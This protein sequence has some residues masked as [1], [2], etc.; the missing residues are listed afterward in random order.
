VIN[1]FTCIRDTGCYTSDS[2]TA[3][4]SPLSSRFGSI[5]LPEAPGLTLGVRVMPSLLNGAPGTS[6][7]L[8]LPGEISGT[9]TGI[10]SSSRMEGLNKSC[11]NTPKEDDSRLNPSRARASAASLSRQRIWWSS[12]PPN[13]SSNFLTPCRHVAMRELR[14]FVSQPKIPNFGM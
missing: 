9:G 8:S 1:I 6:Y 12:K 5:G 10:S 11:V 7:G 4:T 3:A 13:S 14:Q 2:I